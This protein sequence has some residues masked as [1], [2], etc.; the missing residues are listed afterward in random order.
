LIV[1]PAEAEIH[2]SAISGANGWIPAFAGRTTWC[3][4]IRGR[5]YLPS[6]EFNG[7]EI[8]FH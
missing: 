2:F 3:R 1:I 6:R 7:I 8:E 4:S 5:L